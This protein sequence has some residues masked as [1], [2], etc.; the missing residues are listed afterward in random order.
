MDEKLLSDLGVPGKTIA[1]GCFCD[2]K[3]ERR[4][5]P[6]WILRTLLYKLFQQNR[7]LVKYAL[8]HFQS[9]EDL[10]TSN[11][12]G[13]DPDEF[14]SLDVLQ[15]IFEDIATDPEVEV[16]YLVIDGLDECGPHVS[17]IIRLIDELSVRVS[18]KASSLGKKFSLRS[19]VSDR[20]SKIVRDKMGAKYT[21][22]VAKEN[23]R[24]ID[25]VVDRRMRS[26]QEYRSFS[27]NLR[28]HVTTLL[29]ERSKGM[30][31]WLSLV[32]DD[33]STWEGIW[34]ETRVKEKLQSTP[35]DVEAFYGAMLEEQSR[36][37]V[38]R[39]RT[40]L[41]WVFFTCRPLT[42]REVDMIL[43]LQEGKNCTG[44]TSSDEDLEALRCSIENSWGTLFVVRDGALHLCHGSVRDFLSYLF[45]DEGEKEYP[46]YGINKIAA[47]RQ[48]A[49][50]CLTYLCLDEIQKREVPK[51]PVNSDGLIDESKLTAV[52]QRYLDRYALL[53][54]AV[55]FVGHHLRE[56]Q[57]QEETDVIGMKDF[58]SADSAALF[59]WVKSYDLL[60][61]WTYGKC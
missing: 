21:I 23:Q 9:L 12:V 43:I 11:Q 34:T 16:L 42:L 2:D 19:I 35:R 29:R 8:S 48:M 50:V 57:I 28:E 60:K 14:Q 25:A 52:K 5:T 36:D 58:F 1:V 54:Y 46:R 32:L 15:K 31:M 7:N 6:V 26:I 59:S 22:D 18:G 55:E 47:H 53:Q 20:S 30:F 45:S 49:A 51:P 17:A 27:E 33:L 39:L 4:R 3:N 37:V 13:P 24:D 44:V 38:S 56:S 61:R 10:G 40:L 41:M